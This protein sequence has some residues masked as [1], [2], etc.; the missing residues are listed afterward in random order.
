MSDLSS[1]ITRMKFMT[2]E[3]KISNAIDSIAKESGTTN[4]KWSEEKLFPTI[5]SFAKKTVRGSFV[6]KLNRF[7]AEVGEEVWKTI[8]NNA[9]LSEMVEKWE[10]DVNDKAFFE[11]C[12]E[13]TNLINTSSTKNDLVSLDDVKLFLYS[14]TQPQ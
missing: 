12:D 10:S 9:G 8:S 1:A 13:V 4:E 14:M 2:A 6:E 5:L 3:L 7:K 11:T